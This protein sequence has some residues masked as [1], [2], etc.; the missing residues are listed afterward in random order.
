MSA[1]IKTWRER[2]EGQLIITNG[3][4]SIAA[5]DAEIAE[6]RAAGEAKEARIAELEK[7]LEIDTRHKYD[8]ID[9]RDK[10]IA[11]LDA[12]L[13]AQAPASLFD[14]K[15]LDLEQRGYTVIGRILHKD[16]QYA[17]FDSSCR[18]L[19]RPQYQ[20]LMHEQ[21]GSLFAQ[22]VAPVP[23]TLGDEPFCYMSETYE[24]ALLTEPPKEDSQYAD[25]FPVYRTPQTMLSDEFIHIITEA[26]A[27]STTPLNQDRQK[28]IAAHQALAMLAARKVT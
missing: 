16:G 13:K 18:W 3:P 1:H 23:T 14:R 6:L 9:C 28:I 7:R 11:E 17:L 22:P 21:D 24:V 20:R 25:M 2:L 27:V 15:L 4:K 8:G 19:T 10:T 5:R 12:K 26:L